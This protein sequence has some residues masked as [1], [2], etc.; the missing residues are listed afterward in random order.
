M[1][2][3]TPGKIDK[4]S[5]IDPPEVVTDASEPLTCEKK[6][7]VEAPVVLNPKLVR[8]TYFPRNRRSFCVHL[9]LTT[10]VMI[11]L[12]CGAIG[13]VLFYRHLNRQVYSGRCGVRYSD[14][15]YQEL[16]AGMTEDFEDEIPEPVVAEVPQG[17]AIQRTS[18][19][20]GVFEEA[21][22]V[23]RYDEYEQLSVPFFDEVRESIVF[24][25]YR[26]NYTA[27]IDR[28]LGRCFIMP[29]NRTA[30]APPSDV[31]D[32]LEKLMTGYYMK[33]ATVYRHRYRMVRPSLED[34]SPF[35]SRIQEKCGNF[36]SN[37]LEKFVSGVFKRSADAAD[38]TLA[39]GIVS[40]HATHQEIYKIFIE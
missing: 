35:G 3:Y 15:A 2:I 14:P 25:D 36:R 11:I 21:I 7:D 4:D 5:N 32:L 12:A 28:Q 22:E 30:I 26:A 17:L 40:N 23:S 1:T 18:Y 27:I 9:M 33:E 24:H 20:M 19:K 8:V 13:A 38:V 31:L 29:L 39:Y 34:L 37:R 16:R 10:M 6:D